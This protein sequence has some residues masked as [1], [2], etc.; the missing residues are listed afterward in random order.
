MNM[1]L[2]KVEGWKKTPHLGLL[3]EPPWILWR[4]DPALLVTGLLLGPDPWPPTTCYVGYWNPSGPN[5]W[6]LRCLG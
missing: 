5:V 2:L 4:A 6:V 1:R 3:W